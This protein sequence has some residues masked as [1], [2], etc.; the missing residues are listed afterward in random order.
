MLLN[1]SAR[2]GPKIDF[3]FSAKNETGAENDSLFSARKRNENE[4]ETGSISRSSSNTMIM[5]FSD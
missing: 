1:I 3:T 4:N 2:D 5:K